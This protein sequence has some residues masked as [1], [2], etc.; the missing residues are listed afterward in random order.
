MPIR[1]LIVEDH[2][3]TR[4]GLRVILE[5]HEG[6]AVVGESGDGQDALRQ[7]EVLKPDVVVMDLG[8]PILD[9]FEAALRLKTGNIP[10]RIVTHSSHDEET[11]IKRALGNGVDGYCLKDSS[12]N[13]LIDAIETV[14]SG[15]PWLDPR[16]PTHLHQYH[17]FKK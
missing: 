9:G 4:L 8:L 3:I 5:G 12:D 13:F 11:H 15:A 10:V 16:I 7:V 14:F 6:F 2:P 1:I 17:K